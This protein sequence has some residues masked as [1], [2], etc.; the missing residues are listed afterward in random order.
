MLDNYI[1]DYIAGA[2]GAGRAG[3]VLVPGAAGRGRR[4]V[5]VIVIEMRIVIVILT[6]IMIGSYL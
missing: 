2:P 5:I 1:I 3:L 4:A 6:V